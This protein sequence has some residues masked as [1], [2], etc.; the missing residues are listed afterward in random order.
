MPATRSN[1]RPG[2]G[3]KAG[4]VSTLSDRALIMSVILRGSLTHEGINPQR[5][6]RKCRAP[7]STMTTG[8]GCVGAILCRGGKFGCSTKPKICRKAAGGEVMTK[9]PHI[10]R[11][12]GPILTFATNPLH[13]I[14]IRSVR[15]NPMC[16]HWCP[17]SEVRDTR[18]IHL[19][20]LRKAMG[21]SKLI[22]SI[23]A[24]LF[25]VPGSNS[26]LVV[27]ELQIGGTR[28]VDLTFASVSPSSSS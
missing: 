13:Q 2:S 16:Q 9:R 28:V 10:L 24:F 5:I 4:L 20:E 15:F 7:F 23:A 1:R 26:P 27:Q 12:S 8:I 11:P 6:S 19:H 17:L 22:D 18:S 14:G 25:E 21:T 3:L